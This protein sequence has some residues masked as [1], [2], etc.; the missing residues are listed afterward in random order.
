MN[1]VFNLKPRANIL[2][3]AASSLCLVHCLATPLLFTIHTGQLHHSHSHPFW[4]GLIDI[5]FIFISLFAVHWSTKNTSKN[6]MKYALWIS[7]VF[8]AT[9]IINEKLEI[10]EIKEELIY[11][12]SISLV[13]LHLYNRTYCQCV[14]DN[15]CTNTSN[16]S[17]KTS[18][19]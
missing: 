8:L 17:I 15:C 7:W 14:D 10:L 18:K 3:V 19:N 11:L 6:G 9:I 4:W 1:K 2:G 5:F 16:T 13:L 12:P